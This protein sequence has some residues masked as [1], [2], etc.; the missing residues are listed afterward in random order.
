MEYEVLVEEMNPCGGAAHSIKHFMDVETDD[1]ENYVRQSLK[2]KAELT[3]D[4][5]ADGAVTVYVS[6]NGLTQKFIFTPI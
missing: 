5:K 4:R 1:P 2:G 6:C 3:V